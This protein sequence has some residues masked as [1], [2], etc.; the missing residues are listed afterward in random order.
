[1]RHTCVSM[2][3]IGAAVASACVIVLIGS[4]HA[5]TQSLEGRTAEQAYKN[6]QVLQGIPSTDLMPAMSFMSASLGVPCDHCHLQNQLPS[7]E[8]PAKQKAR[9]MIRMMRERMKAAHPP[10]SAP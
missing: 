9:A 4:L 6:I 10:K 8:K 7:D 2:R 5:Q 3:R 1:M